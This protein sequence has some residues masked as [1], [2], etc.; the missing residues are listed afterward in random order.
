MEEG[1][2]HPPQWNIALA[3]PAQ[4]T[5]PLRTRHQ[6]IHK[7]HSVLLQGVTDGHTCVSDDSRMCIFKRLVI[8]AWELPGKASLHLNI[9]FTMSFDCDDAVHCH[10]TKRLQRGETRHRWG[11]CLGK[12]AGSWLSYAYS[13]RGHCTERKLYTATKKC[14]QYTGTTKC[15]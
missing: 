11:N 5:A 3:L 6:R 2:P 15:S 8:Q 9:H 10:F 13:L 1:H 4:D 14:R 7:R 12:P